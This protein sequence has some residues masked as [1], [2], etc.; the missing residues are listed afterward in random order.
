[1]DCGGGDA[2]TCDGEAEVK[3]QREVRRALAKPGAEM[4]IPAIFA[5][6]G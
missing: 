3:E 1:M 2:V 6:P 5:K 4:S